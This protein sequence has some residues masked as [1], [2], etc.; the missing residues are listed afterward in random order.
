V[1]S[2]N[3]ARSRIE[4]ETDIPAPARGKDRPGQARAQ[5]VEVETRLKVAGTSSLYVTELGIGLIRQSK[6]GDESWVELWSKDQTPHVHRRLQVHDAYEGCH[7]MY[8]MSIGSTRHT[9]PV[10]FLTSGKWR[11]LYPDIQGILS[12]K[13]HGQFVDAISTIAQQSPL[14]HAPQ[15]SGFLNLGDETARDY[16]YLLPDG[17]Y[18]TANGDICKDE[19]VSL[20]QDVLS[21]QQK[22]L[23][24]DFT[25]PQSCPP[26]QQQAYFQFLRELGPKTVAIVGHGI[27]A[28]TSDIRTA[29][30]G[31]AHTMTILGDPG[32]GKTAQAAMGRGLSP[33][34]EKPLADGSYEDTVTSIED[35]LAGFRS[36]PT[37]VD[38]LTRQKCATPALAQSE[39]MKADRLARAVHDERP[40]RKRMTASMQRQKSNMLRTCFYNTWETVPSVPLSFWR[41]TVLLSV[42]HNDIRIAPDGS[43]SASLADIETHWDAQVYTYYQLIVQALRELN[44]RGMQKVADTHRELFRKLEISLRDKALQAWEKAYPGIDVPHEYHNLIKLYAHELLGIR[45]LERSSNERLYDFVL[46][47]LLDALVAQFARMAGIMQDEEGYHLFERAFIQF[48][49]EIAQGKRVD[50]YIW[51]I[52]RNVSA[53]GDMEAPRVTAKNGYKLSPNM[54]GHMENASDFL[55]FK[56]VAYVDDSEKAEGA[57]IYLTQEARKALLAIMIKLPG[58]QDITSEIALGKLAEV[59][60]W[61]PPHMRES[62]RQR[63]FKINPPGGAV[64]VWAIPLEKFL[65]HFNDLEPDEQPEEY[66]DNLTQFR[67]PREPVP[68]TG[69][70]SRAVAGG[71][72]VAEAPRQQ[73]PYD[74]DVA[75]EDVPEYEE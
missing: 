32:T 33:Y 5:G 10:G 16:I 12:T 26:A 63:T 73:A 59:E 3:A 28:L 61:V 46:P 39:G 38:D 7:T 50:G 56:T 71:V 14:V 17:R 54:F 52:D 65:A 69:S 47:T 40:P 49:E 68:V 35:Q 74:F 18:I 36:F 15:T 75:M 53:K 23:W 51:R 8:D 30:W 60:G 43:G 25:I 58:G 72:A 57:Y 13:G 66:P 37:I 11:D 55:M 9:I 29:Q 41:R 45:I 21:P 70:P 64:R 1:R 31:A 2:F 27:R 62:S 4:R 67:P 6:E 20:A 19:R 48:M 44:T 34:R 24:E 42:N 22:D